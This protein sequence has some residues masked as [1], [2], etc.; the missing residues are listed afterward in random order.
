LY[1]MLWNNLLASIEQ[2]KLIPNT[3]QYDV[4]VQLKLQWWNG[5]G[6]MQTDQRVS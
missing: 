2:M 5:W 6:D 1:R 4:R 3:E